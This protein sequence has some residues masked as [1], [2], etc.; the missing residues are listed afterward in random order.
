MLCALLRD[1]SLQQYL[2]TFPFFLLSF[3]N[4]FLLSFVFSLSMS[5]SVAVVRMLCLSYFS[6]MA[7]SLI[8]LPT[9]YCITMYRIVFPSFVSL[10]H[11]SVCPSFVSLNHLRMKKNR[12]G[13]GVRWSRCRRVES[14]M[15]T[16]RLGCVVLDWGLRRNMSNPPTHI[17]IL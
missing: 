12:H 2:H 10:N 14:L 6:T 13:H 15:L 17:N 3:L 8:A 1:C 11:L 9:L 5:P 7:W 4:F 16:V